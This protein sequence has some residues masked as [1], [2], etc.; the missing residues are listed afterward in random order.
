MRLLGVLALWLCA[1]LAAAQDSAADG[2]APAAP[3]SA[4]TETEFAAEVMGEERDR[5][6]C[7]RPA[8]PTLERLLSTIQRTADT[9]QAVFQAVLEELRDR[10]RAADPNP[11]SWRAG[12]ARHIDEVLA[13]TEGQRRPPADFAAVRGR[14][15]DIDPATSCLFMTGT[16]AE[17][18][19]ACY[20][21]P[22]QTAPAHPQGDSAQMAVYALGSFEE[23]Y[24]AHQALGI[25]H[26]AL[27]KLDVPGLRKAVAR[28]ALANKR[29]D[30]L[31][32][33]G[34]LQYPWELAASGVFANY[35]DFQACFAS[36]HQCTGE[37]GLDPERVRLILLHPGV[38]MGFSGFGANP[39]PSA[40]AA[41]S[42]SLEALGATFYQE[43][44]K[45]Y[46]GV[47]VGAIV[48]DGDFG[49]VRPGVFVHVTRWAHLG[50]LLSLR[51]ES[52]GD[53]TIFLSSDFGTALGLGF[54]E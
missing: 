33:H 35:S 54:L 18:G 31:R 2:G 22:G 34:Y 25:A 14:D 44:F 3:V 41:L 38:G 13:T 23:A 48:N 6:L 8:D 29:W 19:Y 30:N 49:D 11:V 39:K 37:E 10:C 46:F 16:A 51:S 15:S 7:P 21:A 45:T 42:L 1:A 40:D 32:K 26:G 52:R 27:L 17:S 12:L 53:A 9:D 20:L 24:L 36:D 4:C 5:G 43:S 47:S 28:L 50:Y